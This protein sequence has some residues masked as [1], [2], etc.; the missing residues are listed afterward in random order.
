M[1]SLEIGAYWSVT[2]PSGTLPSAIPRGD[3]VSNCQSSGGWW[4]DC[5]A[6]NSRLVA[7]EP[8]SVIGVSPEMRTTPPVSALGPYCGVPIV[9]APGD[10]A[11]FVTSVIV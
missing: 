9:N 1:D 11:G 4:P 7:S 3:S 8:S 10:G 6:L 2:L 5:H